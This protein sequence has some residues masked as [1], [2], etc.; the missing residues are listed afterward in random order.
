MNAHL[1][2]GSFL[3]K[4]AAVFCRIS[5]VMYR[6]CFREKWKGNKE[7]KPKQHE[8]LRRYVEMAKRMVGA[9]ETEE[10]ALKILENLGS[11]G[12]LEK[13]ILIFT[14]NKDADNLR[15][16]T[17]AFV[18]SGEAEKEDADKLS[19]IDKIKNALPLVSSNTEEPSAVK[20]RLIELGVPEEEASKYAPSGKSGSIFIMVEENPDGNAAGGTS[21]VRLVARETEGMAEGREEQ[22]RGLADTG[23]VETN[24]VSSG[25]QENTTQDLK[26]EESL[27]E[28]LN[29]SIDENTVPPAERAG[30]S[31]K[32]ERSKP[33]SPNPPPGGI[34][35][36]QGNTDK[37]PI[38]EE[39]V[40]EDHHHTPLD[41]TEE[42]I[43]NPDKDRQRSKK[44]K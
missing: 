12:Y 36:A 21:K 20:S 9:Y 13:D 39:G 27:K 33:V 40:P 4:T 5:L 42:D 2:K 29:P 7:N 34:E 35:A 31:P 26:S 15:G 43:N 23:I 17:G 30:K 1:N 41:K 24:T 44:E 11:D 32:G 3:K 38:R 37:E 18:E 10:Q 14:T 19:F 16:S 22:E 25:S 8:F 6:D 28:K